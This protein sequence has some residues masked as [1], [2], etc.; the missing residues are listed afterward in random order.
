MPFDPS[1]ELTV[2]LRCSKGDKLRAA[3]DLGLY[4]SMG[5]PHRPLQDSVLPMPIP[6]PI[7]VRFT[8]EEAN[9]VSARAVRQQQFTLREL[10][11]MILAG[12]G[13]QA[14]RVREILYA[15]TFVHNI[16]RYW[17][18]ALDVDEPT[19]TALLAEFPD[20]DPS[21]AFA[22]IACS[23]V[24][25]ERGAEP[26]RVTLEL[27]R[28]AIDRRR[29]L[30]PKSFWQF[31]MEFS[32]AFPLAYDDYSYYHHAD[33]YLRT[34]TAGESEVLRAATRR[35]ARRDTRRLLERV[36]P[37]ERIVFLCPR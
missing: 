14:R 20:P 34:L 9:Y 24:M 12:T 29:W 7:P 26:A 30:R 31:L 21:R 11:D 19:L 16:Y 6:D 33:R 36:H 13:K 4:K 5:I 25:L 10:V 17:W 28:E 18:E 1:T 35:F 15:G 23:R 2:A 32:G 8:E 27:P 37:I 3:P 22:V